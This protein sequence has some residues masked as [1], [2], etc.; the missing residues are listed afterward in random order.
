MAAAIIDFL[1][2]PCEKCQCN[3]NWKTIHAINEYATFLFDVLNYGSQFIP[4]MCQDY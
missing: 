2:L 3:F 4:D 1:I